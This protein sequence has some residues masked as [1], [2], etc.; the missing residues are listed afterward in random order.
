MQHHKQ[1][2]GVNGL[3]YYMKLN[4]LVDVK[5]RNHE[6]FSIINK[7]NL[8]AK[9]HKR[10]EKSKEESYFP[11][12]INSAH[13]CNRCY[14]NVSCAL[15]HLTIEDKPKKGN[16]NKKRLYSQK[17]LPDIEDLKIDPTF[18]QFTEVE[19]NVLAT[20]FINLIEMINGPKKAYIKNWFN[21]LHIE[22]NFERESIT[23]NEK[24]D[25][26][27]YMIGLDNFDELR[28]F[29]KQNS[30]TDSARPIILKFSKSFEDKTLIHNFLDNIR[31][32]DYVSL[33]QTTLSCTLKGNVIEKRMKK[34][35]QEDKKFFIGSLLVKCYINDTAINL[36]K[37]E[38]VNSNEMQTL[39][40]LEP[41]RKSFFPLMRYNLLE[42]VLN[43]NSQRLY[44]LI[45]ELQPP[46]F[47]EDSSKLKP[48][49]LLYKNK[50]GSNEDQANTIERV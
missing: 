3:L 48:F 12:M 45:V 38:I 6:V 2:E 5:F 24:E 13:E 19:S 7:R 35:K 20:I 34:M 9:H 44:E 30:Q 28:E 17:S 31:P 40:K 46:R 33:Q 11:P 47:D 1:F 23:N 50:R 18:Q 42:L 36:E 16:G 14:Q 27:F 29:L 4:K 15:V 21:L 49:E 43:P 22:E 37:F 32:M 10:F 25:S 8:L 26:S 41:K 39:W